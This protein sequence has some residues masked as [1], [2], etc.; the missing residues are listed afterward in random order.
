MKSLFSCLLIALVLLQ[1]FSRELL[2]VNFALHQEEITA[3]YCVNKD[4]PQMQCGGSC[5]VA[6]QLNKQQ[7]REQKAPDS[8]RDK[9]EMLP[10]AYHSLVPLPVIGY[11]IAIR[12]RKGAVPG[13]PLLGLRSIFHP[14]QVA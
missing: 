9:L 6:K 7:E 14:P 1:T 5:Y 11:P 10:A 13:I 2:L 8:L 4:Q 3:R 12:Y